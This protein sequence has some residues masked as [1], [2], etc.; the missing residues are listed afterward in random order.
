MELVG[1]MQA[2][3][4]FG[5]ATAQHLIRVSRKR[6]LSAS[7]S[8]PRS[9]LAV[10]AATAALLLNG[11]VE[12]GF[13]PKFHPPEAWNE[14][15]LQAMWERDADKVLALGTQYQLSGDPFIHTIIAAAYL[16]GAGE[17]ETQD[18]R[19]EAAVDHWR[20]AAICGE[21]IATRQ[22]SIAYSEGK[23]GVTRD[24]S[25]AICLSEAWM[26]DRN[27]RACGLTDH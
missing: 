6:F 23:Y 21:T 5:R 1:A 20:Y 17:F 26:N 9:I 18:A 27:A 16:G 15:L 2:V 22:L 14:A 25:L 24:Q 4:A 11:C 12:M 10:L 19:N 8:L 3:G 7:C 13:C